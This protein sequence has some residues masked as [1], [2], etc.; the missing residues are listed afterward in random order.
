MKGYRIAAVVCS[1]LALSACQGSKNAQPIATCWSPATKSLAESLSKQ[2]AVEEVEDIVK[3]TDGAVKNDAK[4]NI[5]NNTSITLSDIYVA[6]S[7]P[8]VGHL[9]CGAQ[10]HFTLKPV[11]RGKT[12]SSDGS[13]EF[14]VYKGENGNVVSVPKMPISMLVNSTN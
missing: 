7:N 13:M 14:D 10:V 5:E 8:A 12:L 2:M 4:R 9:T 6:N 1:A 11:G 3:K